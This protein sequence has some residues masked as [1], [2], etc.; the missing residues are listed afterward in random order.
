MADLTPNADAKPSGAA[1]KNPGAENAGPT[2]SY[3]IIADQDKTAGAAG[4]GPVAQNP[5]A[6]NPAAQNPAAQNQVAQN[7]TGATEVIEPVAVETPTTDPGT[8]APVTNYTPTYETGPVAPQ[9]VYVTAPTPPKLRSNRG[10]GVAIAA[11]ASAVYAVLL[12]GIVITVVN[13]LAG[14]ASVQLLAQLGYY[15]PVIFFVIGF[16]VLV[17]IVNKGGWWAYIIGS[18]VVAAFVYFGST[19][20]ILLANGLLTS[21]PEIAA[22]T[23]TRALASPVAIAAA[24]LAREVALWGGAIVSRFGRGVKARNAEAQAA[25]EAEQRANVR[26]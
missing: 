5:V 15:M 23:Y 9:I 12:A 14:A 17:L 24:L 3:V 26:A 1:P 10:A 13:A 8:V 7:Q 20:A 2:K 18:I 19:G 22:D 6:H 11:L 4:T 16:V 25:F 21:T